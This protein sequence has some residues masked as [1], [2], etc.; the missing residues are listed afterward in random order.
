[1]PRTPLGSPAP[2]AIAVVVRGH[3]VLVIKRRLD[4]RDYAVLP[5]G[6]IEPGETAAQ[7]VLRELAEECTLDGTVVRHLFD[8]DHGGRSASYFLVDVPDD[9][10]PVLGGDE[11][12]QHGPENTF[13]LLW[14]TA[15]ELDLL[16]L[17]PEEIR[18]LVVDAAR[19]LHVD[20]AGSDD[21]RLSGTVTTDWVDWHGPYA[22][23]AS[24]L[25][26]RL[27]TVQAQLRRVIDE[28]PGPLRAVS[29]CAGD[30][31]DLLGVLGGRADADRVTAV[32][33]ELDRELAERAR[34]SAEVA[35]LANVHARVVDA[36]DP[37]SYGGALPADLVLMAGVF[38]NIPDDDVRSTIERLPAMCAEGGT[39]IWTRHRNEPDLTPTIRGWFA[40]AGF[41]EVAFEAPPDVAWTVGV[42]SWSGHAGDGAL[43]EGRLFTFFR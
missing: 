38:G 23:P 12:E 9:V 27:V 35:G 17:L 6:G 13:Q 25:S 40:G 34:A 21:V 14:A 41:Q 7:A 5:G 37:A 18:P 31:R 20:Q 4:G 22:D 10:E 36:G 29:V 28:T 32:L 26:R 8:G 33:L 30:G 11:A 1:L 19:P 2:R 16:G 24:T 15:P 39:V 3:Q 42:N 43:G